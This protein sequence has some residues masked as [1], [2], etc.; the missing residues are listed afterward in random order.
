M[1]FLPASQTAYCK[2][3][4]CRCIFLDFYI[5]R[6][7]DLARL[8]SCQGTIWPTEYF[9]RKF[10][11]SI[12]VS[13]S[14]AILVAEYCKHLGGLGPARPALGYATDKGDHIRSIKLCSYECLFIARW[15][16]LLCFIT[17]L[18]PSNHLQKSEELTI[19]C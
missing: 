3:Q 1:L 15:S 11:C 19:W 5:T 6:F 9:I 8:G 16:F 18:L 10:D 14:F 13:Q 17:Y 4:L 2:T 7:N 12:R